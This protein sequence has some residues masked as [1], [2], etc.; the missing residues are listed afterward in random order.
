MQLNYKKQGAGDLPLARPA[1]IIL[2]GLF[3]SL[4]NWNTVAA[5]LAEQFAVYTLDQRNHGASPHNDRFDYPTLA[6]DLREFMQQQRI[7]KAHLL[8]H[9]LGGKTAMQFA[10]SYPERVQKLVVVDIGPGA[11]PAHHDR[12]IAALE[13]VD[14]G[15][16][17]SRQEADRKLAE[18]LPEPGLRQFLLMNLA[19]EADGRYRWR[20]NLA[21]I[22]KNYNDIL[23]GV[24]PG[25][26]SKPAL[27]IRGGRSDYI[28]DRAAALI[29]QLFPH[30]R[31]ETIPDAGHWVH[32]EAQA[33]FI[34][35][36]K[37]FLAS[38]VE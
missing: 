17:Q 22:K 8:G 31:I 3:G 26:F 33:A 13:S 4:A 19:R 18:S 36:V 2:H 30:A 24:T 35:L 27:F 9:S 14:L 32:A 1:L 7:L 6:A 28:D 11:Y 15:K 10:L 21:G 25:R 12:V 37:D 5:R 29:K 38:S 20:M 34:N 23:A 16:I